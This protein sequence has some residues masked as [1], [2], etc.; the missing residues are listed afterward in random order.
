VFA[1][2]EGMRSIC[3]TYRFSSFHEQ[4]KRRLRKT[5]IFTS[6][7]FILANTVA[8]RAHSHVSGIISHIRTHRRLSLHTDQRGPFYTTGLF[9]KHI[10]LFKWINVCLL[11]CTGQWEH[12]CIAC[13][14]WSV[15]NHTQSYQSTSMTLYKRYIDITL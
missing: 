10:S 1:W 3:E 4:Q 5:G 8:P 7:Q 9:R 2:S 15:L 13:A 11:I 14:F 6:L 12:T